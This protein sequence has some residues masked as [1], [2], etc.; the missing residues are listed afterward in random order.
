M[1]EETENTVLGGSGD[2]SAPV[3]D[4]SPVDTTPEITT[5]DPEPVTEPETPAKPVEVVS[6]DELID[7]LTTSGES[8][9]GKTDDSPEEDLEQG[10]N[11]E[12]E[13]VDGDPV[14]VVDAGPSNGDKALELLEIIQK[15]VSPH[16]FLTTDFADYTVAEGLLLMALLLA[17]ISLCLKLLKEGFSWL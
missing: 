6:V 7:R 5:P 10:E 3:V 2:V 13:A 11:A 1:N 4:S 8:G 17:V 12:G 16:P 14:V 15:D 9:E